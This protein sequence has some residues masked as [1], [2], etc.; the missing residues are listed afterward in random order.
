VT[1]CNATKM[2]FAK[3]NATGTETIYFLMDLVTSYGVPKQFC[4]Y[5]GTHFKNKEVEKA[6]KRLGIVQIISRAYHPQTNGM[7]QLMN[8]LICNS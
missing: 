8:K 5:R 3:A 6:C 2:A 7:T 4:S 1:T